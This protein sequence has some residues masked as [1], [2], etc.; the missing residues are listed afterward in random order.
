MST[1]FQS[2]L[3]GTVP[4]ILGLKEQ[5]RSGTFLDNMKLPVH[6]WFRYSAGFS[7]E[8]VSAEVNRFDNGINVFDPFAGCGTTLLAAEAAGAN[9]IGQEAH[10]FVFRVGQAKLLWNS[11]IQKFT[12]LSERIIA[13]AESSKAERAVHK[14]LS[15]CYEESAL[16]NIQSL[17]QALV[18]FEARGPAWSLCWLAF[19]AILRITSHVGTAQWQYLL[20]NKSKSRVSS[21]FKA[22]QVMCM[23]MT[24]DMHFVQS[25]GHLQTAALVLEDC[26]KE[27]LVPDG[28]ADLVISSPP[29]INNYDY[30]DATRLEMTVLGEIDKWGDL[31]SKVRTNL[32]R[33]CTQHVAPY[34]KDFSALLETSELL[35]LRSQ[36][37]KVVTALSLEKLSHGG[38]K[39][40]DSMVVHY[41]FDMAAVWHQLRRIAR[42]GSQVC[43]VVG[44]SAPYGVHVPV[45][46]WHGQLALAAGFSSFEFKKIRDRNNKWKNRKHRVP[47]HEGQLWVNG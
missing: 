15:K 3:F 28:W 16:A 25:Q 22:Y 35:P 18:E 9:A 11:D 12:E 5:R 23:L 40:Y 38:K 36:M 47:L 8:W 10:P 19:V 42:P 2:T 26:R 34:S 44:D 33:S 45:E 1:A 7:A 31:Q 29:Y 41:F 37:E 27:G 4:P 6:R 30:A 46:R 39:N 24:S 17:H 14:L 32:I 13:R 20:P 21:P 43:F